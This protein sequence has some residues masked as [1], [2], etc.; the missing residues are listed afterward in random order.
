MCT[1]TEAV[2]SA[3][4]AKAREIPDFFVVPG[5]AVDQWVMDF[6]HRENEHL[7]ASAR[8]HRMLI[9]PLPE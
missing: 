1:Q 7:K 8:V 9:C 5:S 2:S 3:S 6:I 4:G